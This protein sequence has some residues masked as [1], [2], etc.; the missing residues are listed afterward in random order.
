M[1]RQ[2]PAVSTAKYL[3]VLFT[4][5]GSTAPEAERLRRVVAPRSKKMQCWAGLPFDVRRILLQAYST[6]VWTYSLK[7]SF[8]VP[9]ED[10][11]KIVVSAVR[12]LIGYPSA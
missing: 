5:T 8:G 12:A 10:I 1:W 11:D 6:S 9:R 4:R 2:W 3:G 7:G